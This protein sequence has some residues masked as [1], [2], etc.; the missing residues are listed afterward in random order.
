[1]ANRG[2][3]WTCTLN[4]YT[5]E[6]LKEIQD[7]IEG[8]CIK[9]VIGK[10][11]GEEG[12]PHLQ[13]AF[14]LKDRQ[15]LA[16]LK[17][18]I[19]RGH[20]EQMKKQWLANYR[21]CTKEGEIW[22][23]GDCTKPNERGKRTDLVSA[24]AKIQVHRSWSAVLQDDELV[25]TV[26]SR[27]PWAKQVFANRPREHIAV[28]E[29]REWQRALMQTLQNVPD[30]RKINWILDRVGNHG[31]TWMTKLLVRNFG[32]HE[33]PNKAAEAYYLYQGQRI[34]IW[35]LARTVEERV[36]YEA[37][38]K[39]K[40]AMCVSTKYEPEQKDFDPPHVIVF[41]NFPPD[42]KAWS[43]DRYDVTEIGLEPP[44]LTRQN[45]MIMNE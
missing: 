41:A 7:F 18:K 35:D 21:Y 24:R 38:E 9:G 8:F 31:K 34:V 3:N 26:S 2:T 14:V 17:E 28:Y 19:P 30:S 33:M 32:A 39:I 42:Y 20:F 23:Y 40:N 10:E 6:E 43:Q 11:K 12:T 1:M 29:L 44:P 27:L 22:T 37:I 5:D 36:P 25:D 15:R 16:F 13:C 45:A 4:N